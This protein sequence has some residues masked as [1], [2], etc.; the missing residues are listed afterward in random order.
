MIEYNI[1]KKYVDDGNS[2]SEISEKTNVSKGTVRHYLSKYNLQTMRARKENHYKC[3]CGMSHAIS[4]A[5]K[6]D[7]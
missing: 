2:I 6:A 7:F 5:S 3:K 4:H 1:I